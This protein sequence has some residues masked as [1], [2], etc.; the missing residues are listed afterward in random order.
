[1]IQVILDD[2]PFVVTP[3]NRDL[4]NSAGGYRLDRDRF[5]SS[6]IQIQNHPERGLEWVVF[7]G[8]ALDYNTVQNIGREI[9]YLSDRDQGS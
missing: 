6:Y 8:V 3:D 1:M 7:D 5:E 4:R 2:E 9:E